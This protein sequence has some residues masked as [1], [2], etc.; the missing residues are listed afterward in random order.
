M[1]VNG[2]WT[3]LRR[4]ARWIIRK[5][6]KGQ[7]ECGDFK[8]R[9]HLGPANVH[10][11]GQVRGNPVRAEN[12]SLLQKGQMI[13][14]FVERQ[15][16]PFVAP[17]QECPGRSAVGGDPEASQ[18][19][20]MALNHNSPYF[21]LRHGEISLLDILLANARAVQQSVL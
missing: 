2:A 11:G 14:R 19:H 10:L 3:I 6:T 15:S 13:R 17:H 4:L 20:S 5:I 9:S 8:Q 16:A 7:R 21:R 18:R 12:T 1:W